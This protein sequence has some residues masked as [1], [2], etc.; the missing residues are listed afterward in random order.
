MFLEIIKGW[1]EMKE[2]IA[3]FTDKKE[4]S[5]LRYIQDPPS[6]TYWFQV[7]DTKDLV[8]FE[9]SH[10]DYNKTSRIAHYKELNKE[11]K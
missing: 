7:K 3:I 6:D 1:N 10:F 11:V 8:H 9:F 5:K 2:I 4:F